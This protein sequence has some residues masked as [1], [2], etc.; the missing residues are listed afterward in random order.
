MK[1][2]IKVVRFINGPTV[3]TVTLVEGNL[4]AKASVK[5]YKIKVAVQE[6]RDQASEFL[7]EMREAV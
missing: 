2:W 7:R 4:T 3:V 6:A 5:A 1:E